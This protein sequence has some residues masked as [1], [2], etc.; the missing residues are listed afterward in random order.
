LCGRVISLD[1]VVEEPGD[2]WMPFL[3]RRF[4]S[5]K[6]DELLASD[7]L[8]LG[9]ITYGAFAACPKMEEPRATSRFG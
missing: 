4:A 2:W 9:R 5:Y 3:Q 8:L 7:A 6:T 1:V